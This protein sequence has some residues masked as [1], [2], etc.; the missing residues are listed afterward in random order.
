MVSLTQ[1][2]TPKIL[3]IIE[4]LVEFIKNLLHEIGRG[5]CDFNYDLYTRIVPKPPPKPKAPATVD[6]AKSLS[7]KKKLKSGKFDKKKGKRD[8]SKSPPKKK[9]N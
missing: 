3:V 1:S 5:C 6:G 7:G 4:I 8:R 2:I 9:K